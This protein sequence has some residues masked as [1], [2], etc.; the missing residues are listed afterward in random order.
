MMGNALRLGRLAG[1]EIKLDYSWFI[2]FVIVTWSLA[3][4][5]F[6]GVQ[7]GW[8]PAVY[9][10]IGAVTSVLFFASVL[11]HEMAHSIVSRLQGVP[12][13]D[14]TLFIFGGA[15]RISQGPR[16]PRDEFL[17]AV[18]GPVMSVALAVAFGLLW[19]L[20]RASD[21]P[22]HVLTGWLS[23]TNFA[24]ALF[25]M[26]PGFPLDGGRVLR[27][28]AWSVTGNLRRATRVACTVGRVVAFGFIVFGIWE[29]L[30][31]SWA[32]G[33]WIAVIGWFLDSAAAQSYRQLEL[34]QALAGRQ[35]REVMSQ[36]PAVSS[37]LRLDA[38]VDRVVLPSGERCFS[39]LDE[40]RL[41]GLLTS[42]RI[43]AV[44]REEWPLTRVDEVMIPLAK[45]R[46]VQPADDLAAAFHT[47][48]AEDINLL[49]V[50]EDG[51]PVGVVTRDAF[52]R[53]LQARGTL[54]W[55]RRD[56]A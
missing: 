12:V 48:T 38:V 28:I 14:I 7:P 35:V 9:W 23:G 29:I 31:G 34:E 52:S 27:A 43:T 55:R 41:V 13:R 44:P 2:V 45:L 47:M 50:V 36:C 46:I 10:L 19:W 32:N 8:S 20:S 42:R 24:L 15:A 37:G 39:V 5:Y 33:L 11:A 3:V 16:R 6:P 4:H 17:M 22:F 25:N 18:V 21:S 1:I 49:P 56:A 54:G 51:R 30:T 53:F 40:G 26:I